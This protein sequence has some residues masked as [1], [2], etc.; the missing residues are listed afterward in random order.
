MK[1][2]YVGNF[3]TVS[4]GEPEIA[5]TLEELGHTV[6]RIDEFHTDLGEIKRV[7]D[8]NRCSLL[9]FAKFRV[10][11]LKERSDFLNGLKIPK[12]CWLFD[13]YWGLYNFEAL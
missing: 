12:V 10:G 3:Q 9:L 4:V 5:S 13:L 6:Y 7:I 8:E 2:V 1:I 11:S